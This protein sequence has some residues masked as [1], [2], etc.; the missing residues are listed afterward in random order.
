MYI[1]KDILSAQYSFPAPGFLCCSD[2][3]VDLLPTGNLLLRPRNWDPAP[4]CR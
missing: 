3:S 4:P 2:F 1:S